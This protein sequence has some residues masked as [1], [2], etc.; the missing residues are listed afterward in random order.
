MLFTSLTHALPH[1]EPQTALRLRL[2]TASHRRHNTSLETSLL[3]TVCFAFAG[4]DP[5]VYRLRMTPVSLQT[6]STQFFTLL[7]QTLQPDLCGA[8]G[9]TFS[10]SSLNWT[11]P[12][13]SACTQMT[14]DQKALLALFFFKEKFFF[15]LNCGKV[16]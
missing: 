6:S 2:L 4:H 9:L 13:Y 11:V 5:A 10:S 7:V 15:F 8:F 16:T 3:D 1:Q 12:A 14:P